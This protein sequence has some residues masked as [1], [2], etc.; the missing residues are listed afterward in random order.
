MKFARNAALMLG[1]FAAVVACDDDTTDVDPVDLSGTYTVETFRYDADASSASLDLASIPPSQGGPLGITSMTVASDHSF[2]G[3][4]RL[5]V[6]GTI[7]TFDVGGDIEITGTN[8]MRIDFDEATDELGI[9]DDFED[10][11]FT[12]TGD[13]LTL[14]LPDV[15]FDFTLS[16]EEPEDADLT[17]VASR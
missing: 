1:L 3:S 7:V 5:P 2:A 11:T 10:G 16:G 6:D 17:I 4:M 15:T 9:L 8:T 13:L 12:L 14:I